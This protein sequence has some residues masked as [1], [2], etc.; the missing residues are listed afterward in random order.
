M[1]LVFRATPCGVF[2]GPDIEFKCAI[3]RG[4]MTDANKKREGDG[5][6]PIGCWP[7]RRVFYRADKIAPIETSLPISPIRK[8]DGW[9]DAPDDPLYNQLVSLPYPASHE[10]MWRDDDVYDIV[11]ELGHN[12]N[13]PIPGLGSAI[14]LHLAKPG[15]PPTEGCI[16]LSEMHLRHVLNLSGPETFLDICGAS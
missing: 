12:H 4:G 15:Y 6:S 5:T 13:P 16:A 3:G 8:N 7:M 14:F 10:K 9:C 2:S 11:V 1:G